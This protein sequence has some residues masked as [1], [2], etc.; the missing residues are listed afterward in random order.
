MKQERAKRAALLADLQIMESAAL[1]VLN[2]PKAADQPR[3]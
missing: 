2:A 1:R 3:A